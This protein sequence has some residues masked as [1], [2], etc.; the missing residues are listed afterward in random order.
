M[1]KWKIAVIVCLLGGLL[2][3]GAM[4]Q[5]AENAPVA[6]DT[7]DQPLFKLETAL[8]L[9]KFVGKPLPAW[10]IPATL[11]TN[12]KPVATSDLK[13]RVTLVEIFRIKCSHCQEAAPFMQHLQDTYGNQGLKI[14]ALQAPGRAP[15]EHNWQTVQQTV[16]NWGL[17]YPIGFDTKSA[18]FKGKI[19]SHLYPTIFLL[20]REGKV[21]LALDGLNEKMAIA[22]ED[23]IKKALQ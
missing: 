13:S 4:K 22:L 3:Y 15:E 14:V 18:Y 21:T 20:D 17:T 6:A 16:K 11:W 1:E 10:N 7:P 12:G 23:R 19:G 2:G 9:K 5:R 8:E